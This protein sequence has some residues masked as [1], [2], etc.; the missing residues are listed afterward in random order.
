VPRAAKQ[1]GV[2]PTYDAIYTYVEQHIVP[3]VTREE[4]S[5]IL[6]RI[7]PIQ[8]K[9]DV[10]SLPETSV[11]E[12]RL[13]ICLDPRNNMEIYVRYSPEGQL[14]SLKIVPK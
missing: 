1:I 3:G 2:P 6:E 5:N 9:K 4:V 12:I 7:G 8:V 13:N 11:D 10:G 14:T